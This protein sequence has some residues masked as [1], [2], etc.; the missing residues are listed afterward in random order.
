[1]KEAL[2]IQEKA[3]GPTHPQVAKV[4]LDY[5]SLLRKQRR[6]HEAASIQKRANNIKKTGSNEEQNSNTIDITTLK[7]GR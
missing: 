3:L 4:L 1:L 5:A 7:S 6:R 2:Q